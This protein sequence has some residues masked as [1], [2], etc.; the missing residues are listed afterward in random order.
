MDWL[1]DKRR[2]LCPQLCE[3]LCTKISFG[4]FC[5]D[6]KFPSVRETAVASGVNSNTVQKAFETLEREGILYSVRGSGWD[7]CEDISKA[8]S[9]LENM[10]FEKTA[11]F[12]FEMK[13]IG[14]NE[15]EIKNYV[16]EWN[17]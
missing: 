6:E 10:Y 9:I 2:P 15:N 4:E 5:S 14:L 1:L 11:N 3:Q 7:V 13:K 8:K 17:S 16:K 12:F